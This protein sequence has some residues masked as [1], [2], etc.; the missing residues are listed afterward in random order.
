METWP[1]LKT[2]RVLSHLNQVDLA[3]ISG[4]SQPF[5]SKIE[6]GRRRPSQNVRL[7]IA[8]ALDADVNVIFPKAEEPEK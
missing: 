6:R 8:A 2:F 4:V 5:I 1:P 3:R 7:R